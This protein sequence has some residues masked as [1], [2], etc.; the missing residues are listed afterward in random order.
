MRG[1]TNDIADLLPLVPDTLA[2]LDRI[3]H[4]TTTPGDLFEI[5]V[6]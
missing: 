3:A 5:E 4:G 1:T 6:T 2:V